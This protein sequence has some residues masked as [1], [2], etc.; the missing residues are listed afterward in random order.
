MIDNRTE[1]EKFAAKIFAMKKA[2]AKGWK[3]I[4]D[5]IFESPSGSKH[6]LSASD[7][8]Q[9]ERIEAEGLPIV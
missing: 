3:H 8:N 9:L 7:L 6:D 5:W 1:D 2:H 4:S